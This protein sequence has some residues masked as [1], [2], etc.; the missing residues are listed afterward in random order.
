MTR[1]FGNNNPFA[2]PRPRVQSSLGSGVIVTSDGI[3]LTNNH[4]IEGAD[5]VKI[6]LFDGRELECEIVLQG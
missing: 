1:F 5:E 3:V 2:Q 6:A 4:V